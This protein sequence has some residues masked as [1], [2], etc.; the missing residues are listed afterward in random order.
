[1]NAGILL[2]VQIS[3]Q[4]SRGHVC[5]Q[6]AD[7][8]T[9]M[10]L[11]NEGCTLQLHQ[12]QRWNASLWRLIAAMETQLGCLVG[13]NAYLTPSGGPFV[14]PYHQK[15]HIVDIPLDHCKCEC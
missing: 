15:A 14:S 8:E 4:H 10:G 11:Y 12:P 7:A 1:M 13:A 6:E 3:S 9:V 2:N 5:V